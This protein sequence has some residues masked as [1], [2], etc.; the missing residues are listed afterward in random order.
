M[1][2]QIHILLGVTGSIAAYKAAELLRLM[3]KNGWL[4]SVVMTKAATRFVGE[5]TFQTLSQNPVLVDE[6]ERTEEWDPAHVSWADSADVFV[7][8][9]CTANVIAKLAHGLAD[10]A[11]TSTALACKAPLVIAPAMNENMWLHPATQDNLRI[12]KSRRA[13]IVNPERGQL[14]CGWVGEG[15]LAPLDKIIAIVEKIF[16]RK[17]AKFAKK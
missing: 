2:K 5:L 11:L 14:A 9:P 8:A 17:G 4:V 15:R 12:I 13:I 1:P 3:K 10:D 7:I 16:S 6:F